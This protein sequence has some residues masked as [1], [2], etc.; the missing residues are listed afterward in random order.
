MKSSS[1]CS[2]IAG[3]LVLA[4]SLESG[5]AAAPDTASDASG[6]SYAHAAASA[7]GS[8][9]AKKA[10]FAAAVYEKA[11][12]LLRKEDGLAYAKAY[13][14]RH[15]GSLNRSQA[16]LIVLQLENAANRAL[17]RYTDALFESKY[18]TQLLQHYEPGD[19]INDLLQQTKDAGLRRLLTDLR[20]S[21]FK[22]RETEGSVY[23]VIDYEAYKIYQ[24]HLNP[25]IQAYIDI[26]GAESGSPSASDGGLIISWTEVIGRALAQESFIREFPKSN[27][28][29]Q[30]KDMYKNS[31]SYLYYGLPNSPVF[32]Y[33]TKKLDPDYRAALNALLKDPA[34]AG[35]LLSQLHEWSALLEQ[36]SDKLTEAVKQ[37]RSSNAPDPLW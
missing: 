28:I 24:P 12:M 20:D 25:D 1:P 11:V 18:Q 9:S 8:S 23:P 14:S 33:D 31:R 22:L 35:S 10:A 30:V 32:D 2:I 3:L 34:D 15:V 21:G 4:L 13:I 26:M 7:S 36:S 37:Y 16:A 5:A 17:P 6:S 19:G 27:R 29:S